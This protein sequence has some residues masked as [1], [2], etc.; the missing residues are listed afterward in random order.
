MNCREDAGVL[1]K[2]ST[3]ATL[4]MEMSTFTP[5]SQEG[6]IV[7]HQ[8]YEHISIRTGLYKKAAGL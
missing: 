4:T 2:F 8:Y 1:K 5:M 3:S 6:N 7:G